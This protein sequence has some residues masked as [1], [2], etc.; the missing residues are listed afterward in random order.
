[1]SFLGEMAKA[2]RAV[3]LHLGGRILYRSRDEQPISIPAVFDETSRLVASSETQM[4]TMVPS[5][6]VR[7]S[8]LPEP[9][10][11]DDPTVVHDGISYRVTERSPDGVG[12]VVLRHA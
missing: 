7:A 5:V 8:D 4:E 9:L 1:M 10:E 3:Q 11:T 12:G 2:D 6:F